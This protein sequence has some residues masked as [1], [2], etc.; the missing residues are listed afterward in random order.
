MKNNIQFNRFYKVFNFISLALVIISVLLIFFKGLNFGVDFKGGT[1]IELRVND[2]QTNIS[3]LRSAFNSMNLGDVAIKNF[4]NEN[5]YLIKFE[6]KDKDKNLIQNIKKEL[7]KKIGPVYEFRRVE[8]VGPKVS[9][10]LLN[11]GLIAIAVAL[12]A[13]LF[14]IWIRFEWQFS[15]GAIIAL[16]H[17]VIITI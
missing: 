9:A 5:D 11:K 13:M 2:K 17:D 14:Y 4:G 6:K 12:G 10:E 8:N 7:T 16:F 1:L 15:I 3:S